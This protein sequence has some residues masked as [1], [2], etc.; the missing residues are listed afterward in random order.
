MVVYSLCFVVVILSLPGAH[1]GTVRPGGA[2]GAAAGGTQHVVVLESRVGGLR[3][4][5]AGVGA[6]LHA[7]VAALAP[8]LRPGV[9]KSKVRF[10]LPFTPAYCQHRVVQLFGS[11]CAVH[12][13]KY[14]NILQVVT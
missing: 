13:I 1:P 7:D 3:E 4:D 14:T 6:R 10:P 5:A 11:L 8:R 12:K 9:L 2:L